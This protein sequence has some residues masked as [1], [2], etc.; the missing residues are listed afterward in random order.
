MQLSKRA[1]DV[2]VGAFVVLGAAAIVGGTMWAREAHLGRGKAALVARFRDVGGAGVG[3]NAY[4]RGVRAG[5]VEG[6]E[7][8]DDGWVRV[9]IALEPAVRL[10]A[11]PV[12]LL[13]SSSLVGDWQATITS[14]QAVPDAADVGQQLAE[15]AGERGVVPGA[16]SG[17]VSQ[18]TAGAGR[19]L[20]DIG[21]VA[22]HARVAF[23]DTAALEFRDAIAS[24][25][26]LSARL[27]AT[28]DAIHR[29]ALRVDSASADG[30]LQRALRDV[31]AAAAD[32]RAT[33][34]ELRRFTAGG[35]DTRLL[36]DRVL[37]RVDTLVGRT[38]AGTGTMGRVMSDPSLYTNADS[39]VTELRALVADV[40]AHP[41][42]YVN[43]KMF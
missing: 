35:G 28:S 37:A 25:Q 2:M 26:V 4:I 21:A 41:K 5:R 20:D 3:T 16:M 32:T 8:G 30:D 7:L 23:D 38:T 15:S 31:A 6:I 33:A 14:R 40:K 29:T 43:I 11:D 34:A 22:G 17:G 36:V 12:V 9:R 18:L 19:I 13:G 27:A 42:R 24:T 10:P 1:T 39:L